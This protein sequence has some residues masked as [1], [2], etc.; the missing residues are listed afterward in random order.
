MCFIVEKV[1]RGE[2]KPLIAADEEVFDTNMYFTSVE[3][4]F[5]QFELD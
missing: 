1:L 2:A 3:K 5:K 4:E